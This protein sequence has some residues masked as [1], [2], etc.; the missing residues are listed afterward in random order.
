M[1]KL[2]LIIAVGLLFGGCTNED[3]AKTFL[4]KQGYTNVEMTGHCWF[5]CSDDD[6]VSTGFKATNM[7]GVTITGCVCEGMIGK[8]KT[9]RFD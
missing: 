3:G 6:S 9:I 2:I 4:E 7:N 8:N 1:K 5:G